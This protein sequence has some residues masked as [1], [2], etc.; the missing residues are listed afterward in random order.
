[1]CVT[2]FV[3]PESGWH[4]VT[5]SFALEGPLRLLAFYR[6]NPFRDP[7][8]RL[9]FGEDVLRDGHRHHVNSWT[10]IVFDAEDLAERCEEMV[11]Q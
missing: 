4:K 10:S 6:G 8:A 2:R 7:H 1:M 5:D 11:G 9:V 3:A